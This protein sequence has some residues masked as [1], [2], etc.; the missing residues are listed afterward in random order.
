MTNNKLVVLRD[1]RSDTI[2]DKTFC[3]TASLM[4]LR[5]SDVLSFF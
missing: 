3:D 1:F 5:R 2:S 4:L